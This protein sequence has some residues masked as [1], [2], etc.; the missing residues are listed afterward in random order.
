MTRKHF[1]ALAD[2]IANLSDNPTKMEVISAIAGA[3]RHFNSRFDWGKFTDAC[4][5]K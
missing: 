2:A 1:K 3:C 4:N 5:G